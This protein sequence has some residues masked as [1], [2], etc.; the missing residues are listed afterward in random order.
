MSYRGK[1]NWNRTLVG[2][3]IALATLCYVIV[4]AA[5]AEQIAAYQRFQLVRLALFWG[6][7]VGVAFTL[8][9]W[10]VI[11]NAEQNALTETQVIAVVAGIAVG[12]S[13]LLAYGVGIPAGIVSPLSVSTAV[14]QTAVT[15]VFV[16]LGAAFGCQLARL[17]DGDA[18]LDWRLAAAASCTM[19]LAGFFGF[20]LYQQISTSVFFVVGGGYWTVVTLVVRQ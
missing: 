1:A 6:L 5:A 17:A 19:L 7:P 2:A 15:I 8:G 13:H 11:A 20:A 9:Y 3:G 10:I 12:S 14:V 4:D 18:T 16:V